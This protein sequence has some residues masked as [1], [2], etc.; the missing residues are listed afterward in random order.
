MAKETL[1]QYAHLLQSEGFEVDVDDANQDLTLFCFNENKSSV[2]R[3]PKRV[4]LKLL[5]Q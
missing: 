1:R 5:P 2:T 4:F 3:E